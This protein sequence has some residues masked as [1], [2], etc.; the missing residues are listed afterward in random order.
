MSGI[1]GISK[2]MAPAALQA[3]QWLGPH[4]QGLD[5]Q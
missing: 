4:L 5:H 3:E 2:K 1:I